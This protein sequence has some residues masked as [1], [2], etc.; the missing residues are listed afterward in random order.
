MQKTPQRV[1]LLDTF[2]AF[3]IVVGALQ[4]AYVVL[5]GNFVRAHI[6][7]FV[8]FAHLYA[9]RRVTC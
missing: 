6:L 5:V 7:H 8:S 1:K 9:H 2:M 4:F 3:L